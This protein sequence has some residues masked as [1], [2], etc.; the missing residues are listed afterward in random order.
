M[1]LCK[2]AAQKVL[3]VTTSVLPSEE[4]AGGVPVTDPLPNEGSGLIGAQQSPDCQASVP[5]WSPLASQRH[6][7]VRRTM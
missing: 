7:T 1:V 2:R 5:E 3:K 6:R 4:K